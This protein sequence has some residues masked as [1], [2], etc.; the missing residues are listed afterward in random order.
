MRYLLYYLFFHYLLMC[1]L[2]I[3]QE[4][5]PAKENVAPQNDTAPGWWKTVL[6]YPQ[7]PAERIQETLQAA[8]NIIT[9]KSLTPI[10]A[11]Q[12]AVESVKSLSTI[13]QK[14]SVMKDGKRVLILADGRILKSFSAP[15]DDDCQNWTRLILAAAIESFPFSEKARTADPEEF[16][17]IFLNAALGSMDPYSRYE[18]CDPEKLEPLKKPASIGIGYR[19]VGKYLE[20]T[21]LLANGTAA[22]SDLAIGDRII[23]IDGK[24]IADLS[25]TQILNLLRGEEGSEVTLMLRKD[26]QIQERIL[27][28]KLVSS[29][30]VSYFF[31]ETDKIMTIKISAFTPQTVSGL[32]S[33]LNLAKQ[34][35]AA[36]LIIDLRSNVGGLLKEAVLAA[37]IF[38]PQDLLI[39]QTK[40]RH[41]QTE[42]QYISTPK[43]ERPVYPIAIL[44][45]A[46]TASSAEFFAGVLQEYRHAVVIGTPTYGKGVIQSNDPLPNK[47]RL[48]LTWAYF[49]LPS[50]YSPQKY[51]IY[52]NICTSGKTLANIDTLPPPKT[53]L[54]PFKEGDD[55]TKQKTLSLCPAEVRKG[56]PL[57]EEIAKKILLNQ[58]RYENA[59]TYFS[60]DS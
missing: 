21:D 37:D 10:S 30:P 35:N 55:I 2:A 36:G 43:D 53:V 46:K 34:S 9:R 49:Q 3:A 58:K 47:G 42:Q 41:P 13:D 25:Q 18:A 24:A 11:S 15:S 26:G 38:L 48:H 4:Q 32:K 5:L 39:I 52:P 1:P 14:I 50:G 59:L 31:D 45:D 12:I 17:N 20:I 44:T 54:Q 16:L 33:T 51:G 29:S 19:R 22:Q 7:W 56:N 57:D 6:D 28:R 60:L 8:C 27:K 23:K 40:G